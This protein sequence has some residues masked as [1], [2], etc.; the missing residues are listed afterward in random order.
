MEY[1]E[2]KTAEAIVAKD[3]DLLDQILL[4][5]EYSHQGNKEADIWLHGKDHEDKENK[6]LLMLKTESA[7]LVGRKIIETTP[8]DWW[9]GAWSNKNR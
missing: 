5:K 2:R 7:K 4:L 6:Q 3:A 1:R 9:K 8:S